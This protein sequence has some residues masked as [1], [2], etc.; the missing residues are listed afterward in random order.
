MSDDHSPEQSGDPPDTANPLGTRRALVTPSIDAVFDLLANPERRE[1]CVFLMSPGVT[2]ATV[3]DIVEGIAPGATDRER[4]RMA[5][6]LHHRHLPK[7][8]EAGLIDYD[9]RSHTARYW[10]Q[11]SVEKWAEH[12][13]AVEDRGGRGES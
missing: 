2:V 13:R 8:A 10:G 5:I 6:D 1:V 7:L 12:V 9:P 11:P 4:E 3:E